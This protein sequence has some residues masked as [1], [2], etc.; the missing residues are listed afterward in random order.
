MTELEPLPGKRR[1]II[2]GSMLS[3]VVVLYRWM[4]EV[5]TD[6]WTVE[7]TSATSVGTLDLD[8]RAKLFESPE[9][10]WSKKNRPRGRTTK[11]P[12]A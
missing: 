6:W 1:F 11:V 3:V 10:V 12:S 9:D 8:C 7:E 2:L 4:M 5:P